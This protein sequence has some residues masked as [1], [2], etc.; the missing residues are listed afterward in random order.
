MWSS[1]MKYLSERKVRRQGTLEG[2]NWRWRP[3]RPFPGWPLWE[4][5]NPVPDAQEK[6]LSQYERKL[7]SYAN[8]NLD[9]ISHNWSKEDEKLKAEYCI[10]K[11]QREQL[12]KKILEEKGECKIA[13]DAL[14][15]A[16]RAYK[17]F[18]PLSL[19]AWLFWF[20]FIGISVGE[21]FINYFVF[22]IFGQ[23][24]HETYLMALA[25][26]LVLPVTAEFTGRYLKSE[27][28]TTFKGKILLG[29]CLFGV[30]AL[31]TSLAILREYFFE[32]IKT[33]T[34]IQISP[35][36][37]SA[38]LIVFNL[39]IFVALT[40]LAYMYARTHPDAYGKA[41]KN[42]DKACADLRKEGGDVENVANSLS[43]AEERYN[44]AHTKRDA[45][46]KQHLDMAEDVI[47]RWVSY[48]I[49]Y[50][51]ANINARAKTEDILAFRIDPRSC[52]QM[53][54]NLTKI[55]WHC[56]YEDVPSGDAN[57][58]SEIG[59]NNGAKR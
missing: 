56:A 54:E 55:D 57:G 45:V 4:D 19:P 44:N 52:I 43:A 59:S 9:I 20:L 25:I 15:I 53:P 36:T 10:A 29:V 31:L 42:Y 18:P 5:K 22:Q 30:V 58:Q 24:E 28:E 48:V 38:I 47:D 40:I 6:E 49:T 3:W 35:N 33:M 27:E 14:L 13:A 51:H 32:A 41:S 23:R 39:T 11:Q 46:Y 12:G 50:R 37:L 34:N 26:V 8:Q 7:M 17:H 2:R 1:N 21:G 16:E